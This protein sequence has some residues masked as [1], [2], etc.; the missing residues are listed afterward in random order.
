MKLFKI[1]FERRVGDVEVVVAED[2]D[3]A[4]REFWRNA[5]P[6]ERWLPLEVE[7]VKEVE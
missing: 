3:A 6:N 7:V 4:M 1:Y 5:A 2:E